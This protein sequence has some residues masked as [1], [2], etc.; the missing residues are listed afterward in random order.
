VEKIGN[1]YAIGTQ[2]LLPNCET[3]DLAFHDLLNSGGSDGAFLDEADAIGTGV[4]HIQ[5]AQTNGRRSMHHIWFSVFA[6]NYLGDLH[7]G[8]GGVVFQQ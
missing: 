8:L 6:G 7:S 5:D 1:H 2:T 3:T 4:A